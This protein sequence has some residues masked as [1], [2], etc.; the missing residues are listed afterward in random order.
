M[1]VN[2]TSNNQPNYMRDV[3]IYAPV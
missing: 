1:S 3:E 2:E